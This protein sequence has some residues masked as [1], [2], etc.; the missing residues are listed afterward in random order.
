[1]YVISSV[2]SLTIS[3][4]LLPSFYCL[5]MAI[6]KDSCSFLAVPLLSVQIAFR[7]AHS[8]SKQTKR[9]DT[10]EKKYSSMNTKNLAN[11]RIFFFFYNKYIY[12]YI[13]CM[14]VGRINVK[15]TM[16]NWAIFCSL[17]V[18]TKK[19]VNGQGDA[20]CMMWW[21]RLICPLPINTHY[22]LVNHAVL[23]EVQ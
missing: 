19:K 9:I 21:P 2:S 5:L 6:L 10:R 20:D 1:M 13:W 8:Q 14:Y 4:I 3:D 12:I 23:E 16:T 15:Q 7:F 17:C 18:W 11:H 22:F